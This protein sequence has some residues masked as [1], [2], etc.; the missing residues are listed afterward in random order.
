MLPVLLLQYHIPAAHLP[1]SLLHLLLPV[2]PD[3]PDMLRLPLP[4]HRLY[5]CSCNHKTVLPSAVSPNK[6]AELLFPLNKNNPPN[7]NRLLPEH[8]LPPEHSHTPDMLPVLLPQY[9]IPAAHL[10]ESLPHLPLPAHLNNSGMPHPL[11][12]VRCCCNPKQLPAEPHR[13]A[14]NKKPLPHSAVLPAHPDIPATADSV[15]LPLPSAVQDSR[16]T[17]GQD[18]PALHPAS[19]QL[20]NKYH[21]LRNKRLHNHKHHFQVQP[22]SSR[23]HK[24][25]PPADQ[26][27]TPYRLPLNPHL[28]G[29]EPS[30]HPNKPL[31]HCRQPPL[32]SHLPLLPLQNILHLHNPLHYRTVLYTIHRSHQES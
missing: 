17:A 13:T 19:L 10:P 2:L 23:P 4:E 1:E 18:V 29:N 8:P 5:R 25:R 3:K 26:S 28:A 30:A 12:P 31:P 16:S 11:L 27:C 7:R 15:C 9:R 6:T 20:H 32:R 22:S 14:L 21:S 24:P